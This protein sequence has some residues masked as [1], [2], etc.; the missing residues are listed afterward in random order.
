MTKRLKGGEYEQDTNTKLGSG[1]FGEVF[2]GKIASSGQP[3]AIKTV[4]KNKIK[5]KKVSDQF[6]NEIESL[7]KN[8]KFDNPFILKILDCFET[9]NNIYVIT[10]FCEGNSLE[11]KIFNKQ[12]F[13]EQQSLA[14][15]FQIGLALLS[16]QENKIVHRDITKENVYYCKDLIKLAG[17]GCARVAPQ[18]FTTSIGS[19]KNRAPEFYNNGV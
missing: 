6:L 17:F 9:S 11:T 8:V 16:L 4:L 1:E 19:P 15:G 18:G 14:V 12:K 7:E 10:E 3:C 13:D 5:D 2:K